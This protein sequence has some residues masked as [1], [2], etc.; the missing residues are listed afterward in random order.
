M[1]KSAL[2]AERSANLESIRNSTLYPLVSQ[3]IAKNELI[4]LKQIFTMLDSVND[5]NGVE[6]M[7]AVLREQR[8]LGAPIR[9]EVRSALLAK[10]EQLH[11]SNPN[12]EVM[13]SV[14]IKLILPVQFS[15]LGHVSVP[16]SSPLHEVLKELSYQ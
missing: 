2:I 1:A 6:A 8:A 3:S 11:Q 16:E 10:L 15:P 4:P 13:T 5:W 7:T 9:E 14:L 12:Q